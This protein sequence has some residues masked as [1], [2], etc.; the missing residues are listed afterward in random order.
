MI[1]TLI[2]DDEPP[3]RR[4]L[5]ALLR[6][7][8]DFEIVGEC[9]DGL[10]AVEAIERSAPDLVFLDVQ[11]P[12]MDGLAVV[13]AVGVVRMPAVV[14]VTAYDAYALR[15]F[16][17]HA[18]D[19]L[20]KPFDG[21]RFGRALDHARRMA[22]RSEHQLAA[23]LRALLDAQA[24]RGVDRLIVREPGRVHV[25]RVPD[26]DWIEAAGNYVELHVGRETHLVHETMSAVA[27]RLPADRFRRIHRSTI[28]NVERIRSIELGARGDGR[29]L[30]L[31]GTR[32]P[33]S[34]IHRQALDDLL[35][36]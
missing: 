33:L 25:V 5:R 23:R 30:L 20:L 24:S 15:A 16:E 19:Y 13:E 18:I 21:E 34:R 12:E 2:V 36:R 10:G 28:V 22:G 32:L 17:L 14:F 8:P 27:A 29:V 4:R 3:A 1:R 35:G 26:I 6:E 31:D 11:M 7:A 9:E